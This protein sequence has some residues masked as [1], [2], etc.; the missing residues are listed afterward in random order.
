MFRRINHKFKMSG[1]AEES[2]AT[3]L[4]DKGERT[5]LVKIAPT[6]II[7][8]ETFRARF[9]EEMVGA[10]VSSRELLRVQK[11]QDNK[12]GR[13]MSL[14]TDFYHFLWAQ[15]TVVT[16]TQLDEVLVLFLQQHLDIDGETL[17]SWT[18]NHSIYLRAFQRLAHY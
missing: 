5:G 1:G 8:K 18:D 3:L 14:L 12:G 11:L 16:A 15:E 17:R 13:L 7:E 6:E 9:T 4:T 10:G 2:D